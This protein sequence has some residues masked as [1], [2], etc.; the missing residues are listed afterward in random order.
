MATSFEN[1]N[2][3][4]ICLDE[5]TENN[6]SYLPCCH[7]FHQECFN[8]YITEK[9]KSKKNISCPI[10]RIEHFIYGQRNYQ[11]IMNELGIV[12]ESENSGIPAYQQYIPTNV[13]NVNNRAYNITP[14]PYIPHSVITMP[15]NTINN[16]QRRPTI[17]R[18]PHID[19]NVIW[20]KFRYYLIGFVLIGI[21]TYVSFLLISTFI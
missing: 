20:L 13:Y 2:T 15:M 6:V 16:T 14:I 17:R 3:C 12:Y 1:V 8:N 18:Q 11:F 5:I 21:L 10:C 19:C 4:T 9:I 7:G